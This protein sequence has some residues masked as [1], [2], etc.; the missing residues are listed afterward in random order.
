VHRLVRGA[1]PG[2]LHDADGR[3]FTRLG[4]KRAAQYVVRPDG[5]IGYRN[6]GT[7]L[8]GLE[9]YLAR[10]LPGVE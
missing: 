7:D 6:G 10:W 9:R 1:T 4:V 5:H 8:D 2:D 3:A